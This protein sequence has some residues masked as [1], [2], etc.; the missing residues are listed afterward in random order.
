M[1][2]MLTSMSGFELNQRIAL[3]LLRVKEQEKR[4]RQ[5]R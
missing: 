5:R 2:Q 3:H 4:N 1:H